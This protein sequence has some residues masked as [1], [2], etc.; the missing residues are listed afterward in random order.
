VFDTRPHVDLHHHRVQRLIDVAARVEDRREERPLAQLR[1][2]QFNIASLGGQQTGTVTVALG[3]ADSLRWCRGGR[4]EEVAEF[5]STT[6]ALLELVDWLEERAVSL[7]A[8]EA[9]SVYGKPVHWVLEDRVERVWVINAR[10]MRN[11]PGRKTDV[12]D[13]QWGAVVGARVGAPVVR[14]GPPDPRAARSDPLSAFGDR[15]T[16]PRD[17]AAPQGPRGRRDQVVVVHVVGADQVGPGDDR[18]LVAGQRDP[19]V[20]AQMAR[21][22]MRSKIP[23]LTDALDGRFNEHHPE[24]AR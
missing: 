24:C 23:E 9:T 18:R 7:V 8:M 1:D 15:G 11:V 3:N 17:P 4:W 6:R 22:R 12:A 10:H 21:G 19:P 13:A 5:G 2:A 16:W 20:L 14:A